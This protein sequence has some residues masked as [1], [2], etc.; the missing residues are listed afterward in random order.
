MNLT[1]NSHHS[2]PKTSSSKT[3]SPSYIS[4][5][6]HSPKLL[7]KVL[8]HCLQISSHPVVSLT[9]RSLQNT[10]L[11]TIFW[12]SLSLSLIVLMFALFFFIQYCL[13]FI[14][15][16]F[17]SIFLLYPIHRFFN[18]HLYKNHQD[19]SAIFYSLINNFLYFKFI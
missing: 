15:L 9:F 19:S 18:L 5:I 14:T 17:A 11:I 3:I 6:Y 7:L 4:P 13:Y 2:L 1:N 10:P 12:T 16:K 8:I